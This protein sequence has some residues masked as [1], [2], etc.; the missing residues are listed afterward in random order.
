MSRFI[1]VS[2]LFACFVFILYS[3]LLCMSHHILIVKLKKCT[4]ICINRLFVFSRFFV[5]LSGSCVIKRGAS[6]IAAHHQAPQHPPP[7]HPTAQPLT[8]AF[9]P[10]LAPNGLYLLIGK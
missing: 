1:C 4:H 5:L 2:F 9:K 3:H 6:H 7:D 10:R 8:P